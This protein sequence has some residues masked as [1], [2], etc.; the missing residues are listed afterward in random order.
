MDKIKK[1]TASSRHVPGRCPAC[2]GK[3]R[4]SAG[5]KPAGPDRHDTDFRFELHTCGRQ[6]QWLEYYRFGVMVRQSH[7]R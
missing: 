6:H 2:L 1:T 5:D 7:A 3:S 4:P